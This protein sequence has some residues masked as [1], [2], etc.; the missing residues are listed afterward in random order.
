MVNFA[1]ARSEPEHASVACNTVTVTDSSLHRYDN[2]S[3]N[4]MEVIRSVDPRNNFLRCLS[5]YICY[6]LIV[7]ARD[8]TSNNLDN[9]LNKMQNPKIKLTPLRSYLIE[10][11]RLLSR[12]P[13]EYGRRDPS[14]WPR[15]TLY[16]HKLA[17]T[18]PKSGGRSVG[19]VRS[20]TQTMEF[21]FFFFWSRA[22]LEKLPVLQLH[23]NLPTFCGT[24]RFSTMFKSPPLVPILTQINQSISF[25]LLLWDSF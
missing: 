11:Y 24:W 20:R 1:L 6:V 17:I 4:S 22:L 16:P 2:I 19:I 23:K 14:R 13:T 25:N 9:T 3:T 8:G 10:K 7:V 18:S 21:S 15:G 5:V 12:K